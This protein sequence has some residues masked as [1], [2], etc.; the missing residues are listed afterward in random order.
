MKVGVKLNQGLRG[1]VLKLI[2]SNRIVVLLRNEKKNLT[3]SNGSL[4]YVHIFP[5]LFQGI[6]VAT[7]LKSSSERGVFKQILDVPVTGWHIATGHPKSHRQRVR[8]QINN[9][10][11][12][13]IVTQMPGSVIYRPISNDATQ[14]YTMAPPTLISKSITVTVSA[15]VIRTV[16]VNEVNH[17]PKAMKLL[18]PVTV[19]QGKELRY[20]IPADIIWDPEDGSARNLRLQMK[21]ESGLDLSPAS[22]I[23]FNST[24]QQIYG[25]PSSADIIGS[26]RFLLIATDSGGKSLTFPFTLVVSRAPTVTFNHKVTIVLN[27]TK[28]FMT[29]VGL[30]LNLM[31]KISR[32]YG[33]ELNQLRVSSY[34]Y[35][36]GALFF[37]FQ[38]ESSKV[39]AGCN[40]QNLR[41]G[42]GNS[43]SLN[44]NLI[45]A[46][47]P[48]FQIM[49]GYV[50]GIGR[51]RD[52][53]V[54]NTPP[55]VKRP[56]SS[57][58]VVWGQTLHY[59]VPFDTFYDEQDHYTPNLMLQMRTENNEA[60]PSSSWIQFDSAR[61]LIY[62]ITNDLKMI[63][64]HS[65]RIV[66]VNSGGLEAFTSLKITVISDTARYNHD[67]GMVLG[68]LSYKDLAGNAEIRVSLMESIARYYG[69]ASNRV[70]IAKYVHGPS[71]HFRFDSIPYEDCDN[72]EL[73]RF[74]D[75]FW[76]AQKNEVNYTFITHLKRDNFT[77][78]TAYFKG[79]G[80]C[81]NVTP[82]V[83]RS[84]PSALNRPQVLR[85][86]L[87]QA[88]NF[89]I[90][91]RTFFDEQD[92]FTP[93]LKL[94]IRT[95]KN[96]ELPRPWW[97]VVDARQH[98]L[99][100][101]LNKNLVRLNFFNLV[102]ED[103]KKQEGD[104]RL[105]VRVLEDG[106]Q[107]NHEFTIRLKNFAF[108]DNVAIKLKLLEKIAAYYGLSYKNVRVPIQGPKDAFTF[109][110]DTVPYM[111]C[112]H[113]N[114]T[115]L[116]HGFWSGYTLNPQFV[117]ALKPEFEIISGY[118]KRL[119][120]CAPTNTPPVVENPV[121]TLTLMQGQRMKFHIPMDTFYDKEDGYTTN[122]TLKASLDNN[123]LPSWIY[124]NSTKQGLI[125]LPITDNTVGTHNLLLTAKD[126]GGFTATDVVELKVT[127]DTT[128]FKNEFRFNIDDATVPVDKVQTKI[129]MMYK[130]AAYFGVRLEEVHLSGFGP[131][132]PPTCTFHLKTL[133]DL[134][135]DD[136]SL[137]DVIDSFI[138]NGKLNKNFVDAMGPEFI[139]SAGVHKGLGP[140]TPPPP[141]PN[142][143][144][145]IYNHID[146]VDV[147]Q[148]Q[149]L[150]FHVPYDSFFDKEDGYTPNL[151]L[152]MSTIDGYELLN[153]SWI[154]FNSSSQEIFGLPAVVNRIGLYEI[155]LIA[156]D[157]E[158]A[159]AYDAF[160]V[161]VLEE[162]AP[163]NHK[164]NI[165][166]DFDN[167]TFL[168]NVG[169]RVALLD[170]IA[171]YFGVN[172]TS[173]RVVSYAP[174]VLFSF[175]FDFV[176]YDEC[177][178]SFLT[179]LRDDFWLDGGLNPAFGAALFP[180]F[181]VISGSYERLGPCK[182]VIGP[183]VGAK[184]GDRPGGIWWTYAIIPAI[185]VAIVLLLLGCCLLV[186]MGCCRR[187]K[188]S[189]ADQ[190]TYIYKK[191][192]VV[193]K[194]EYEIKEM[195]LK[196]P[197]VLPNEKPPVPPV[198]PRS[199][200]LGGDKVPLLNGEAKSVPYQAPVFI[201]SRQLGGGG[202]GGSGNAGFVAN[203]GGAAAGAGAGGGGAA[204]L[205]GGGGAGGAAAAGGGGGGGSAA[206][207]G[208]FIAGGGGGMGSGM[209]AGSGGAAFS[210][211]A[212]AVL[213][214]SGASQGWGGG[215]AGGGGG[216]AAAGGGGGGA[217]GG[218]G[219]AAGGGGGGAAGG[220]G[221]SVSYST[222]T[223]GRGFKQSS[224]SYSYSSSS[225]GVSSSGRKMAYSGYR[226]PPAY[227]P[228]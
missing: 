145:K 117:A 224:Y 214:G 69:L 192:P 18:G 99:A 174:G 198:Y 44:P 52:P 76:M 11:P 141:V 142:T 219:G 15:N 226:L 213:I 9:L 138:E 31:K 124:F 49:Y 135:C 189:G 202:G 195:L 190:M 163:F 59:S 39:N 161:R 97:L 56:I 148:G 87:G 131:D 62:G 164:F 160:E 152:Q 23:L 83:D 116:I 50:E 110:F 212:S 188:M 93:N 72:P 70:R 185:V 32:Y 120:P 130:I 228:P 61:Q 157:K 153:T 1:P 89:K 4:N 80:P 79:F 88:L 6:E 165:I 121:E 177:S 64:Q 57:P 51:C 217:A 191:K 215:A 8:R 26:H 125:S 104:T 22:W 129:R 41:D 25:F 21:T 3:K 40:N 144:P 81:A 58:V 60:L 158:G 68:H 203:G 74:I 162:D 222:S 187:T 28:S 29:N 92:F 5:S 132:Y 122:L 20:T 114:L 143:P 218:G 154:L 159:R 13:P 98:I 43:M 186:M 204:V 106:K 205:G 38:L 223:G 137:F 94:Y 170:A 10:R 108:Q 14:T 176:P 207:G 45:E 95:R 173:V 24:K 65:Y 12:T 209:S 194:E 46:L 42:I 2:V 150:R 149:G 193:L 206:A 54:P 30:R 75:G 107:Y 211:A 103:S 210:G 55:R 27:Y 134:K 201:S 7:L 109:R 111:E 227:V 16:G 199:P 53:A 139:V 118:Y 166:L 17:A 183:E 196:Q 86:Y 168:R 221:Y 96:E 84:P 181:R 34:R 100:L 19:Y 101:P 35:Y 128:K 47:R 73:V 36:H 77:V 123:D 216:G 127:K 85:V 115:E 37:I 66:A 167:D 71:V 208:G 105:R 155:L 113:R 171:N 172:F 67:F 220:G 179:K 147:F 200:V 151:S 184:V 140:C 90:P 82:N 91:H 33:I 112:N 225:G 146:R 126:S 102:A 119:E 63:G 197:L 175:Y 133:R 156:S 180:G 136:S 78:K 178:H 169:I 48:E 182:S